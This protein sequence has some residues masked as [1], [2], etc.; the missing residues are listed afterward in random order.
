M[1]AGTLILPRVTFQVTI[2]AHPLH[3]YESCQEGHSNSARYFWVRLT[4]CEA[5]RTRS[6][7]TRASG[8]TKDPP[9][10]VAVAQRLRPSY[11]FKAFSFLLKGE[12]FRRAACEGSCRPVLPP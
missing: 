9:L 7:V 8:G 10:R 11:L 1:L 5:Q 6:G 3:P 4:S 12:G 2:G